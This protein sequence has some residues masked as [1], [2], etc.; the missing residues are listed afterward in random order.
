LKTGIDSA[1][2]SFIMLPYF[3]LFMLPG[4]ISLFAVNSRI[5]NWTYQGDGKE[6]KTVFK[7]AMLSVV[8]TSLYLVA[9]YNKPL[10]MTL[11]P[12]FARSIPVKIILNFV[13]ALISYGVYKLVCA[14]ARIITKGYR[15][16]IAF[17]LILFI[18]LSSFYAPIFI[19]KTTF[20]A[21]SKGVDIKIISEEEPDIFK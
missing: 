8:L 9:M 16:Y 12:N 14:E 10:Y 6:Y 11:T 15:N 4:F 18:L 19:N 21:N 20:G 3:I 17:S 13:I 5:H 1:A 7:I 2:K